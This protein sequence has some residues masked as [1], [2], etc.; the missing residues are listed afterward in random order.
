[1]RGPA[2]TTHEIAASVAAQVRHYERLTVPH[3]LAIEIVAR[4]HNLD[5]SRL[6][7]LLAQASQ[8]TR[9]LGVVSR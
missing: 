8:L 3:P 4:R 1:M 5:R 6:E 7:W 9:E 2:L